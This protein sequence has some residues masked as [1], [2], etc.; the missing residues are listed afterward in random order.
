[1]SSS[2]GK[3]PPV[4]V[5]VPE[6]SG[7]GA[8]KVARLIVEAL[9]KKK[10]PGYL[11]AHRVP[12][13]TAREKV[14]FLPSGR[15]FPCLRALAKWSAQHG[16]ATKFL[17]LNYV[18][19][20]PW[21]RLLEPG[22]RIL[23]R[24][25]NTISAEI[26]FLPLWKRPLSWLGYQLAFLCSDTVVAQSQTM[27]KDLQKTFAGI[28]GKIRILPNPVAPALP[29]NLSKREEDKIPRRPFIFAA[30]SFKPQ[31]DFVTLFRAFRIFSRSLG[32][33]SPLLV[34]AGRFQG[35]ELR[36]LLRREAGASASRVRLAGEVGNPDAW[37]RK[38][39][40]CV[41]SS[42]YEGNSN[43]ILEAVHHRKK[44]VV[45]D[46]PGANREM[47]VRH[48]GILLC[49]SRDPDSFAD[50]MRK[51]HLRPKPRRRASIRRGLEEF[52]RNLMTMIHP[53]AR[54]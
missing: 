44:I 13:G 23:C 54:A 26:R 14:H 24:P 48:P 17:N 40:F 30:M 12:P 36:T 52:E 19:L 31:K 45:T 53:G 11:L 10:T 34:I 1:M 51:A 7:G 43:F 38:S 3:A 9:R 35:P 41:L 2:S 18:L 4:D 50:G 21:L 15:C 32:S 49:R 25:G 16:G 29:A 27:V 37:I 22:C 33:S 5:L 8:E 47:A 39:T 42:H 6:L 20:A 28:R 46:C